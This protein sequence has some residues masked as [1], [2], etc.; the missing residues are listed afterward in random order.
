MNGPTLVASILGIVILAAILLIMRK[1]RTPFVEE[2]TF[3][4]GPPI[5]QQTIVEP[6]TLVSVT[7]DVQS[8]PPLPEDGLPAGWSMEQWTHYGQQYLDRLGKQP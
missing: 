7:E 2:E 4:S 5:S 1:Q 3:V 8:G 6:T